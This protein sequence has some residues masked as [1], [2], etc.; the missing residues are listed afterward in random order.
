MGPIPL[1][2]PIRTTPIHPLLPDIRVPKE[3]LPPHQYNPITCAPIDIAS[4]RHQLH[5]LR[6]EYPSTAAVLK[7]QEE[8]AKEVRE[9]M[10]D[11]ERKRN[12]VQRALDKKIQERD[13]ELKVLSKYQVKASR[14][15]S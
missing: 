8:A 1:T 5:Q 3:P 2:S 14:T 13:T 15:L 11:A 9:R 10:E 6:K 7:A 4:V 12:E